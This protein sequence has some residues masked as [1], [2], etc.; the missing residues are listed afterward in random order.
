MLAQSGQLTALCAHITV[1]LRG[2]HDVIDLIREP[3]IENVSSPSHLRPALQALLAELSDP[4][5]GSRAMIRALLMQ[6]VI[7][8]LRKR[9]S[10]NGS[11]LRW[12]A[13]LADP[14]MWNALKAML[15][16]PGD[17]HSVESLANI[18]GMSRATF[19]KR[20]IFRLH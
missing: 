16:A 18:V 19:A 8:M 12:M 17:D 7:D 13:A 2:V 20:F 1:G 11:A 6:C 10:K 15:D 5:L 14:S 4:G 3:M 9:L